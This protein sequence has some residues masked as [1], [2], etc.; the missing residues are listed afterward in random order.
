M[1]RAI[2]NATSRATTLTDLPN[3]LLLI[4]LSK[5][6]LKARIKLRKVSKL[7]EDLVSTIV[8]RV[9][10]RLSQV[11]STHG[12]STYFQFRDDMVTGILHIP[13]SFNVTNRD[14]DR[15]VHK[16][17]TETWHI[18]NPLTIEFH[19]EHAFSI[20][21]IRTKAHQMHQLGVYIDVYADQVSQSD[22]QLLLNY[23]RLN[24]LFR[25]TLGNRPVLV[26]DVY[27]LRPRCVY[28]YID[29]SLLQCVEDLAQ[30]FEEAVEWNRLRVPISLFI[31]E[32]HAVFQNFEHWFD[33]TRMLKLY[34]QLTLVAE[35]MDRF[36]YLKS[37]VSIDPRIP[38]QRRTLSTYD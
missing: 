30:F 33:D 38:P 31:D 4:I 16:H 3:E 28:L 5:L 18:W 36:G 9:D 19:F 11:S 14:L 20:T 37:R 23:P 1:T 15:M 8:I 17:F 32:T 22:L 21:S 26:P 34:P 35:V 7:F 6:P 2:F 10:V 24:I 25:C 13:Y 12:P 29:P 27:Q